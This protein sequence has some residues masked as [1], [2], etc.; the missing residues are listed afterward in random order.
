M[1]LKVVLLVI[2]VILAFPILWLSLAKLVRKL[3]HFPAPEF[4]ESGQY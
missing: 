2:L 3:F 4:G 1:A